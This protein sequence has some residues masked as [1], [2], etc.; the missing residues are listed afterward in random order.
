MLGTMY[1]LAFGLSGLAFYQFHSQILV[2]LG[3]EGMK[4]WGA[5]HVEMPSSRDS[6]CSHCSHA[7]FSLMASNKSTGMYEDCSVLNFRT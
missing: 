5:H 1:R 2:D 4:G 7:G 6:L 3:F